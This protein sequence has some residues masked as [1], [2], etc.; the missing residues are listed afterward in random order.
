M[1][2][3]RCRFEPPVPVRK[4]AV[5]R[6]AALVIASAVAITP[7]QAQT[8]NELR[9]SGTVEKLDGNLVTLSLSQG[10]SVVARL[11]SEPRVNSVAKGSGSDLK[12]G[13]QVNIQA[14]SGQ[15]GDLIATQIVL[16]APGSNRPDAEPGPDNAQLVATIEKTHA[17]PEGPVLTIGDKGKDRKITIG[18]D[19]AIWIA[20]A[21][22][23]TDIKVGS[24]VTMTAVK[25][26]DGSLQVLR[27][28]FG[29]A[30]V[31]NPP[32]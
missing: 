12:A 21:A 3:V 16:F 25:R 20:R 9:I 4:K 19:T 32:L 28:N 7:A 15:S 31:G 11:D 1:P 8:A 24:A 22:R 30:G 18:P 27:A 5:H 17:S 6:F 10:I 14:K 23:I 26:E 13:S 2:I 29:P